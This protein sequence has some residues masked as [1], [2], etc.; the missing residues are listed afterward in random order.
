MREKI[1]CWGFL[2]IINVFPPS[3]FPA[4]AEAYS[5]NLQSW[6]LTGVSLSLVLYSSDSQ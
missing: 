6:T 1:L 3:P 2:N 5:G 4:S